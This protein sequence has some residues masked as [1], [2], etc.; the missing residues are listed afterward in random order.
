VHPDGALNEENQPL[1]ETVEFVRLKPDWKLHLQSL[2]VHDVQ[3]GTHPHESGARD[4]RANVYEPLGILN[5][6][7]MHSHSVQLLI[8]LCEPNELE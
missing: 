7:L 3:L 4:L 1:G 8:G 2:A 6:V 5:Q